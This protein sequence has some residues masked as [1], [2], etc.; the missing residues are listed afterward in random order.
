MA[1]NPP[2]CR[3]EGSRLVLSPLDESHTEAVLRWRNDPA[4]RIW[5][6]SGHADITPE[7]HLRWLRTYREDSTDY[8]FVFSD[9][10]SGR[11][12]GMVAIYNVNWEARSGEFGRLLVG[13]SQDRRS[14]FAMQATLLALEF[15]RDRL[16][17]G[18]IYLHVKIANA[19]AT[20]LYRAVGFEPDA[21]PSPYADNT[22][23]RVSLSSWSRS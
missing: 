17:L 14:G 8:T 19:A 3:I 1:K 4:I 6:N 22:R 21:T 9:R 18:E 2:I 13:E 5:F 11:H 12:I 7:Q 20:A 23:L 15:S 10:A 16:H